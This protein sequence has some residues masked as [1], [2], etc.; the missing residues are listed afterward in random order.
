MATD[1]VSLTGMGIP[2]L[3]ELL[4]VVTMFVWT[5]SVMLRQAFLPH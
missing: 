1:Y 2:K 5:C 3:S 4:I